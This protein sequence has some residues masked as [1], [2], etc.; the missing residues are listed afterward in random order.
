MRQGHCLTIFEILA[1]QRLPGSPQGE[2]ILMRVSSDEKG[3]VVEMSSRT[4]SRLTGPVDSAD[5]WLERLGC[6]LFP[7]DRP[8]IQY[9]SWCHQVGLLQLLSERLISI[10]EVCARTQLSENGADA[11]LGV[12]CGLRIAKRLCD[13]RYTLS[14]A[15]QEYFSP[16]SPFYI[17]NELSP[18]GERIP[19][20]YIGNGAVA[21]AWIKMIHLL[22]SMRKGTTERLR[23]QHVRNLPACIA[24][25]ESGEFAGLDCIVDLAGGSGAFAIPLAREYPATR[26][27]LVE[28]PAALKNVRSFLAEYGVAERIE[29]V[30]MDV[31][32]PPWKVPE[33]DGLFIGNFLHG[34]NDNTCISV[35]RQAHERLRR[36]G[37]VWVHEML[38]NTNRDGPLITALWN[39]SMRAAGGKQRTAGEIISL[40]QHAGFHSPHVVPT[41]GAFALVGAQKR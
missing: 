2:A 24:A 10:P 21:H 11:L 13:G 27:V 25:V 16:N 8:L 37:K 29:L 19:R 30:G 20:T 41:A 22:P 28:L 32:A 9:V 15:A 1:G 38:W 18:P 7:R 31:F 26:I 33:C 35:C 3:N 34:F 12:L 4:A 23:N 6:K 17:A 39:A 36:G 40:L 14:E 5:P